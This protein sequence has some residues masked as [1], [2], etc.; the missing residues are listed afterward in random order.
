MKY[1]KFLGNQ[2]LIKRGSKKLS[3]RNNKWLDEWPKR[4][5]KYNALKIIA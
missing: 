5:H 3:N 2:S 4:K 1:T